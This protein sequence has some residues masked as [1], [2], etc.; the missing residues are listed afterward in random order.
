MNY[1]LQ[2]RRYALPFRAPVRTAHGSWATREGLFVR[3][4]DET[5]GVGY[6]EAAPVPGFGTETVE[7]DAKALREL[8][9][10][11]DNAKLAAIPTGLACL[12]NGLTAASS[13]RR[14]A[15][16]AERARPDHLPVAALLPAGRSALAQVGPKADAGFRVFKWKVGVEDAADE[17]GLLDDLCAVLPSGGKLR[18]DANGAWNRRVAERWLNHCAERP[19]EFVEQPVAPSVRGAEDLLLGLAADYPTPIALDESLAGAD[20]IGRWLEAGWPG[21]FVVKLALVGDVPAMMLRL[22]EA[23][24]SVVFSSALET[25]VGAQ[26]ALWTAFGWPGEMRALGY[27]VWPLFAD[28]RFDGPAS[29]PFVH[30]EDVK[31]MNPEAAWIALD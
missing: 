22:A 15:D 9:D 24:A 2:F 3:L 23:R 30:W 20:D 11:V 21:I 4:E 7:E 6:G 8:G 17:M 1:R 31:R 26:A 5:G 28:T 14:P 19:V 29:G 10:R 13:T 16:K 27:G 18:L 12:R 25:S